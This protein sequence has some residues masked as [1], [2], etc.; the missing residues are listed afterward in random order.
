MHFQYELKNKKIKSLF[1]NSIK[2]YILSLI[3][4]T[5]KKNCSSISKYFGIPYKVVYNFFDLFETKEKAVKRFLIATVKH[6]STKKNP[7]IL[8]SDGFVIPKFYAKVMENLTYDYN[9]CLKNVSKGLTTINIAWT[10]GKITIPL[11]FNFWIRKKQLKEGKKY[12]KK[13]EIT[14]QLILEIKDKVPFEYV[15]LD[16]D[17]GNREFLT[18]L[19]ENNLK[20]SIRM[21]S[22]R[23]ICV[24]NVE[25]FIGDIPCF[26]LVRN[27]KY[28]MVKGRYKE[29]ESYFTIH[30]RKGKRGKKQTVYIVSNLENLTPKQH[31][32]AYSKRWPIE[33]MHRTLKQHL[34][35]H[36]CQCVS[37]KKQ[38]AHIFATFLAFVKLEK[39]KFYKQ[40]KSPEAVLH[41]IRIQNPGK[42]VLGYVCWEG[43]IM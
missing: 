2:G 38:R 12:S 10:N 19:H 41:K 26:Q 23:K 33:K 29:I 24:D 5:C 42:K 7:G 17:Y 15:A 25:T 21:P 28:K 6:F 30:K 14:K 4:S 40:Q 34:G 11:D 32:L 8:I 37:Q 1:N 18:F 36:Q 3:L 35:V 9:S 39:L 13:T 16:G 22:R 43:A 31:V 27:E 20:Y